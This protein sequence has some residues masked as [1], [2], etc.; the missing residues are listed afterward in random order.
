MLEFLNKLL[1]VGK[2]VICFIFYI[3]NIIK[4]NKL[5]F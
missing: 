4:D 5:S 3:K 2:I 1:I